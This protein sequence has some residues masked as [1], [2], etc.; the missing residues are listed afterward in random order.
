MAEKKK[1]SAREKHTEDVIYELF[2]SME[3]EPDIETDIAALGQLPDDDMRVAG[4]PK[5]HRFFFG[6][7]IFVIIMAIIGTVST[8]R[9]VINGIGNLVDNTS[10][11][12]EFAR[13]LLPVVANDVAPFQNESEI[14]NSAKVN[15]A[16]WNI[17]VNK[18][19]NIYKGSAAGELLIPEYDVLVACKEIF[20]AGAAITHQSVGT[21]DT[22]F[23]Y[24]AD[25]HVYSCVR[26]LRYLN[27]APRIVDMT[28][29]N[30]TYVLTVEY[31]PPSISMVAEN[32]GIEVTAE[33]TMEYTVN[34][35]D[36]KNTLMS[37][38]F[39]N[40]SDL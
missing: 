3:S 40:T 4:N 16:I 17:L 15:C 12:N 2:G 7:A 6:F 37:I 1:G 27:Y 18:D 26:N 9:F 38:K 8:V 23:T 25:N 14:S 5:K 10:L 20:G 33:K 34:R 11:K 31:L 30:G 32:L 21:V 35:W 39:L 13:F 24:D 28:E 22:R 36:G 29:S 19:P